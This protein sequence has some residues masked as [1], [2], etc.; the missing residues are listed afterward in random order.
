MKTKAVSFVHSSAAC[1]LYRSP[2][3]IE[4]PADHMACCAD[5]SKSFSLCAECK[6]ANRESKGDWKYVA[7]SLHHRKRANENVDGGCAVV[8]GCISNVFD[9][10]DV[11]K[12]NFRLHSN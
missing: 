3:A 12:A 6:I 5:Y 4:S 7:I 10:S 8:R 9:S 2:E 1:R 11:G